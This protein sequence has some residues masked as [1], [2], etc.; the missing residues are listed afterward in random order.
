MPTYCLD[1]YL[2]VTHYLSPSSQR[3]IFGIPYIERE[4]FDASEIGNTY[5]L[6]KYNNCTSKPRLYSYKIGHGFMYD[7][8]LLSY[9]NNPTRFLTKMGPLAGWATPDISIDMNANQAQA[10]GII[11]SVRWLG[12]LGQELG[13]V[14]F[15][16]V[17]WAREELDYICF[18]GLRDGSTFFISTL[19][20][21]NDL[22]SKNFIRGYRKMRS[23]F[24]NSKIVNVGGKISGMDDDVIFIPYEESFGHQPYQQLKLLNLNK[25]NERR[26]I[27]G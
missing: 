1:T 23:L 27:N 24:P 22:C 21:K 12:R 20:V 16:T 2:G 14:V 25:I 7:K 26:Q 18:A 5:S 10:I 6:I 13:Q 19:G 4:D 9:L 17:G 3:D 8:S 15:P 11:E